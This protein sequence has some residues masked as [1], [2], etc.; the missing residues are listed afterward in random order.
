[1]LNDNVYFHVRKYF[2][3]SFIFACTCDGCVYAPLADNGELFHA[4][5]CESRQV[6]EYQDTMRSSVDH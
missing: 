6:W 2:R 3:M 4:Q 1:M 5:V